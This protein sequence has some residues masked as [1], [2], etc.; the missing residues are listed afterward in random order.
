MVIKLSFEEALE[1]TNRS[2]ESQIRAPYQML[3][4]AVLIVADLSKDPLSAG[5]SFLEKIPNKYE[6]LQNSAS[7]MTSNMH[8]HKY[9]WKKCNRNE[10]CA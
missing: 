4:V 3:A 8:D 7:S 1:K 5:L 6:C 9:S 10:I 2:K